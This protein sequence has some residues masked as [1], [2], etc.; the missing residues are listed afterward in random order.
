MFVI[1]F[2]DEGSAADQRQKLMQDHLEFLA[3][4]A[5]KVQAAGPLQDP[6][7]G[8]AAGGLWLV[9][10]DDVQEAWKLVHADPFYPSGLRKAVK[11][12]KWEQVFNNV[13]NG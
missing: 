11:I 1:S 12:L 2:E 10:C 3:N 8:L 5:D 7:S 13:N 6:A 9:D 4:N